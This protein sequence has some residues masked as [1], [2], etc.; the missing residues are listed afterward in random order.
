[1]NGRAAGNDEQYLAQREAEVLPFTQTEMS[2]SKNAKSD[3]FSEPL[4]NWKHG[5]IVFFTP[6]HAS[7]TP[8]P[9]KREGMSES[10]LYPA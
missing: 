7:Y 6:F 9:L 3:S 10:F 4:P 1:M 5:Y 8:G 2:M